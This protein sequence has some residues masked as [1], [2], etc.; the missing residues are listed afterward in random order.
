MPRSLG[1]PA[2]LPYASSASQFPSSCAW[3]VFPG[4]FHF[5]GTDIT[6]W[7]DAPPY[8]CQQCLHE[9]GLSVQEDGYGVSAPQIFAEHYRDTLMLP[10][11]GAMPATACD[12]LPGPSWKN[13][14]GPVWRA[15]HLRRPYMKPLSFLLEQAPPSRILNLMATCRLETRHRDFLWQQGPQEIRQA[16]L[17]CDGFLTSLTGKPG[18]GYHYDREYLVA[19]PTGLPPS[20]KSPR[21]LSPFPDH[22]R[23][24]VAASA[25]TP[26]HAHP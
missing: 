3:R 7:N 13:L 10:R 25:R 15:A 22:A 9:A 17:D 21:P 23:E 11:G 14:P 5:F 6:I 2:F 12:T 24:A 1:S 20:G 16:L 4:H 19:L 26:R 8:C 18:A